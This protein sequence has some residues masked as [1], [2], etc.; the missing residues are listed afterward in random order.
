MLREFNFLR[1]LGKCACHFLDLD[2]S[3]IDDV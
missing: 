1:K 2:H 3:V